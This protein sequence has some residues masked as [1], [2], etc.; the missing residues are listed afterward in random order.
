MQPEINRF[1]EESL[2]KIFF[3]K[4]ALPLAIG[5]LTTSITLNENAIDLTLALIAQS[6]LCTA[7]MYAKDIHD[8][9]EDKLALTFLGGTYS[10][11]VIS[12]L[13]GFNNY[14][15]LGAICAYSISYFVCQMS[16]TLEIN[17]NLV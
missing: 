17:L 8:I 12:D 11:G 9:A 10:I 15:T 5:C 14:S 6:I 4:F 16:D 2:M 7:L 13:S 1:A 3:K